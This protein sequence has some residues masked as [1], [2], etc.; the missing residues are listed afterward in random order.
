VVYFC[1][2]IFVIIIII[3]II[4]TTTTTIIIIINKTAWRTVFLEKLT[5]PQLF[6]KCSAFYGTEIYI[7]VLTSLITYSILRKVHFN[8][9][10]SR[11]PRNSKRPLLFVF[12]HLKD[13]CSHSSSDKIHSHM[14]LI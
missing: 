3:V 12:L 7:K 8:L 11:T 6:K 2:N 1:C 9:I 10:P 4:I 13:F 14:I 5:I